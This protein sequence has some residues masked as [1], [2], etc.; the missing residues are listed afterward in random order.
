[1]ENSKQSFHICKETF[2][3]IRSQLLTQFLFVEQWYMYTIL[4]IYQ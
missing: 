4:C 2:V 1:M 3:R